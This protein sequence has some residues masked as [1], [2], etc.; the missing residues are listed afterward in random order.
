MGPL[1]LDFQA[2]L[3][4]PEEKEKLAH[5]TVGGVILF[6]RNFHDKAQLR[7]L[8]ADVRKHAHSPLLIAVDHEGGRVQRFR[9]GFTHLPAMGE[10]TALS[11]SKA[12]AL[13]LSK[14]CGVVMAYELKMMDIDFSFAPVLDINNVSQV[15]GDRAFGCHSDEVIPLAN[16]LIDGLHEGNMPAIGKHFP[17]HGSVTADS[18]IA[19]PVDERCLEDIARVDMAVFKSLIGDNKLDG[20]MPAHVIYSSVCDKPA[21]FSHHWLRS[22]LKK[23]LGF[24]G[25]VFSDDLSMHGASVAGNYVDR[26]RAAL[27]AGCDMVLACNNEKGAEAILDGLSHDEVSDVKTNSAQALMPLAKRTLS[28]KKEAY[29]ASQQQ[30][31][32]ALDKR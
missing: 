4:L 28:I 2:E 1:M 29:L 15:I 3:L 8:I 10:L 24:S 27:S 6:T 13:S 26:A 23:Q 32:R 25:A 14:A 12:D 9:D 7:A 22:V 31:I 20:I 30:V 5:P 18:H 11:D 19:L 16:A 17:G 21:G